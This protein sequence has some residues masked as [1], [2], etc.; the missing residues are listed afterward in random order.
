[1]GLEYKISLVIPAYNEEELIERAIKTSIDFLSTITNDYEII[2]VND[3]SSDRTGQIVDSYAQLNPN[4][5]P[6]HNKNNLGSG[7][8]LFIGLKSARYDFVLTNFADLP[9]DINELAGIL[10]LIV[11]EGIDFVVVTRI[12]RKANSTYRK[13][14]SLINYWL[15][16]LIF[17]LKVRDFQFVQIYKKIII[18]A[19]NVQSCGTFAAPEIII[20]ALDK[21]FKMMEY[22]AVFNPRIAGSS[23]CGSPR[24]ILQ[25]LLEMIIFWY[26]RLASSGNL[27][28]LRYLV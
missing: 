12:N 1:M 7:R 8:S 13:I 3:A 22:S 19:I 21:G 25:T 10:T 24:I 6:I 2:I 28:K 15:I 11:R 4:V 27:G 18:E 5:K 17:N 20:G 16:R 14:T 23:K 26:T 9:F